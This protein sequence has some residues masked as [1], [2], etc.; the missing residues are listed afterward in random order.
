VGWGAG[1][2]EA[3]GIAFEMKMKK[4]SNENALKIK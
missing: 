2:V 4:V 1:W 3:L